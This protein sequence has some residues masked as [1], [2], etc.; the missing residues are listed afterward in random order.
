MTTLTQPTAVYDGYDSF[1]GVKRDGAVSGSSGTTQG[2]TSNYVYVC[3]D[4][5]S[6]SS[7]LSV[8]ASVSGSGIDYS[9][10]AKATFTEQLNVTSTSVVVIVH[11]IVQSGVISASPGYGATTPPGIRTEDRVHDDHDAGAGHV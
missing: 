5:E 8:S 3:T 2:E 6:V 10:S 1:L 11:T 4:S 9:A 7:A